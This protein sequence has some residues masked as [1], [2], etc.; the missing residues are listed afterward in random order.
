MPL[1]G[2]VLLFEKC[3]E[4]A[5]LEHIGHDVTTTKELALD[6]ELRHCRPLRKILDALT[7]L[8]T[9]Q[10]IGRLELDAI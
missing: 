9:R 1:F 2:D 5:A 8:C 7:D 6:V 3:L 10:N 4:L